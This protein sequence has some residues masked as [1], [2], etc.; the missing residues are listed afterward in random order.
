MTEKE[1]LRHHPT[2]PRRESH[3]QA[4]MVVGSKKQ[5]NNIFHF[6]TTIS[7][8]LQPLAQQDFCSPCYLLS[9][10]LSQL[11]SYVF[12]LVFAK[13]QRLVVI[14][15][16]EAKLFVA[17]NPCIIQQLTICLWVDNWIT[18]DSHSIF[19]NFHTV[20]SNVLYLQR[21]ENSTKRCA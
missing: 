4:M 8:T 2:Q 18:V 3:K 16:Q 9:L 10:L 13:L 11:V 7:S 6:R 20:N 21:Q 1:K 5:P 14:M 15:I 12:L 19:A 17:F